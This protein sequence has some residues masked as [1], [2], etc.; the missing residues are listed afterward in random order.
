[1]DHRVAAG[2]TYATEADVRAAIEDLNDVESYRLQ[3]AARAGLMGTQYDTEQ[4]VINE[5]LVRTL[6]AACGERGRRWPLD[7]PFVAFMITTVQGL[8][9]DSRESMYQT[10]T[11]SLDGVA[12]EDGSIDGFLA[13]RGEMHD[14]TLDRIIEE[15]QAEQHAETVRRHC[16]LIDARF[17]EDQEVMWLIEGRKDDMPAAQIQELSGMTKT[18]YE[19]AKRRFNRGLKELFSGGSGSRK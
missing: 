4:D 14:S 3:L 15:E 11:R 6:A 16:A 19:T 13:N 12:D 18:Q 8:C 5:A 1:M 9:S 17:I 10:M 2:S 7:V